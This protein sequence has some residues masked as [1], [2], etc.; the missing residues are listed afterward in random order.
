EVGKYNQLYYFVMEYLDGK[1]LEA[2]LNERGRLPPLE[3]VRIAFLAALGLQ[4][5]FEKGMVHRDLKPANLMLCPA[6]QDNTL[7]PMVKIID[8]GSGRI[9]CDL[10]GT[11]AA[12]NLAGEGVVLGTPNYLAP[13]QARD[14]R[15]V[16]SRADIYS[17]GCVLYHALTRQPPFPDDS[18]IR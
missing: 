6:P 3:A 9:R 10:D 14:A 12:K 7:R 11:G 13:E 17:L 18:L 16:D 2:L 4:H 5:M 1:T 8:L 15:S